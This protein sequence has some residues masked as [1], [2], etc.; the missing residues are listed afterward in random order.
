MSKTGSLRETASAKK[1][2]E[3]R[4][5]GLATWIYSRL[6][7]LYP[8][9]FRSM[10]ASEMQ[11]IFTLALTD[12]DQLGAW[13]VAG[14]LLRE[15]RDIPVALFL[16]HLHERRKRTMQFLSFS[17][18]QDIKWIRWTARL[19]SLVF[20]AM[21]I[22]TIVFY[23]IGAGK[24]LPTALILA[25]ATVFMLLAWRWEKVGGMLTMIASPFALGAVVLVATMPEVFGL[26]SAT[27]PLVIS[28]IGL[29]FTFA[30]LIVGWLF[31]SVAQ[32]SVI[33]AQPAGQKAGPQ[34]KWVLIA[35][36]IVLIVIILLGL[37]FLGPAFFDTES[38]IRGVTPGV[39]L[40]VLGTA[41][42]SVGP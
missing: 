36:G 20:A 40:E 35:G 30:T 23:V 38:V 9:A 5:V 19:L 22:T 32:H 17:T 16:Q 39:P 28:L 18:V 6:L 34:L 26:D 29:A 14:I 24:A 27:A 21:L 3:S 13:A 33:E 1:E 37:T 2:G 15:L 7:R 11:H 4:L 25:V 42:P 12:A 10:F 31:V 41:A 8:R